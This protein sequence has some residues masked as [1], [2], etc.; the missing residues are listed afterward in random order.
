[1]PSFPFQFLADQ[2]TLYQPGGYIIPTQ[3]YVPLRI[4]RPCDGPDM[5][6]S[7]VENEAEDT[8]IYNFYLKNKTLMF[9][10]KLKSDKPTEI[11]PI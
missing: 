4:F 9:F 5:A 6:V 11:M 7:V 1:M 3:Y 8:N 2:L 10:L